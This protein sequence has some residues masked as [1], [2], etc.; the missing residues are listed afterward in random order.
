MMSQSSSLNM[1]MSAQ[2]P[3][4]GRGRRAARQSPPA[5]AACASASC[6]QCRSGS[7]D[8]CLKPHVSVGQINN[9]PPPAPVQVVCCVCVLCVC[10]VCVVLCV[11]CV[12]VCMCVLCV[13]VCAMLCVCCAYIFVYRAVCVTDTESADPIRPA[14][15]LGRSDGAGRDAVN[16]R[17]AERPCARPNTC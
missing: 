12:R 11:L 14:N 2:R 1:A 6:V 7:V 4:C 15:H 9:G 17:H 5:R 16:Q 3:A 8:D 13:C 10:V